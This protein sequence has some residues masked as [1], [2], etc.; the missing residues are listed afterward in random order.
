MLDE[1]YALRGWDR[2]R[3]WPT[4][5]TLEGLGLD[6]VADRLEALPHG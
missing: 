4:R 5:P 6:D 2:D 3:G 1:Y